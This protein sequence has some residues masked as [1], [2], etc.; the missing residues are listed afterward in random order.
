MRASSAVAVAVV[1][2]TAI[3]FGGED[4]RAA[5]TSCTDDSQC[6][7]LNTVPMVC[8]LS[9]SLCVMEATDAPSLVAAINAGDLVGGGAVFVTSVPT[10]TGLLS[11]FTAT[12]VTF[13]SNGDEGPAPAV[14]SL[15]GG[16]ATLTDCTFDQN[17]GTVAGGLIS[18]ATSLTVTG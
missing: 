11:T 2:V 15:D 9:E 12:N 5:A 3:V 6:S 8:R 1:V 14:V 18:T 7:P 16:A 4:A 10:T 17:T 13:R